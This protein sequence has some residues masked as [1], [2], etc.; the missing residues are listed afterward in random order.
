M[1]AL[2]V[3][4]LRFIETFAE[5]ITAAF[6]EYPVLSERSGRS[7]MGRAIPLPRRPKGA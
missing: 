5:V 1:S 6:D 2:L 4:A 7:C 3:W